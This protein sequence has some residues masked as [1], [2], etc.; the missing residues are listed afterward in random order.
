MSSS[1]SI[2]PENNM[3]ILFMGHGSPLNA[4]EDNEFSRNWK[5][6]AE[7]IPKPEKILCISAHWVTDGTYVTAMENPKT[8]HDF[9]GFPK[10]LY[11]VHYNAKGSHDLASEIIKT[12]KSVKILPDYE[13]GIDHGTWS[14][15]VKMYPNADIP[16]L[17]LSLNVNLSP[18]ECFG[19]GEEI[20]QLRKKGVL[21]VGSGNLVHNL[22]RINLDAKPYAWAVDFDNFVKANLENGDYDNLVSYE[23]HKLSDLAHP[24][25]EHYLPLLYVIGAA[26]NEKP[27]FVNETIFAGSISMRCA[28]FI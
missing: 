19:M 25:N 23:E 15:L 18:N 16:V 24:T 12:V 26:E 5:K 28:I 10:E 21:I 4:I 8:I 2:S 1:N 20:R 27:Q 14:L 17:Q 11:E 3:P 6:M 9:Y 7:I 22:M 13:W